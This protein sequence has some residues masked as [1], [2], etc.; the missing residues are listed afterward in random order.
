M[1]NSTHF[2]ITFLHKNIVFLI[3]STFLLCLFS[4]T[5]TAVDSVN[6]ADDVHFSSNIP[7]DVDPALQK[8]LKAEGNIFE[9]NEAFNEYSWQA[10]VAINWP[11]DSEGNAMPNFNDAGIPTWLGWKEAFQVYRKDGGVP[12]DWG[13]P[14]NESGLKLPTDALQN[15]DARMI[16]TSSTP[17]NPSI[18]NIADEVDQAFAGEL[19]DQDGNVVVYEVL[20]NKEEYDYVVDNKLYNINGQIAFS[21]GGKNIANFP[22]G[23]YAGDSLGAI[24]IKFAWKVLQDTDMEERYFTDEGYIISDDTTDPPTLEKVNLGMIGMHISQKTPTGKQWVWST[25]EHIDVLDQNVVEKD[26]K[27][28]VI[29]PSL[30][31]PNCEICPV[32]VDVTAGGTYKYVAG[33]SENHGPYWLVTKKN[34]TTVPGKD[35]EC[36]T[37]KDSLTSSRYYAAY[38]DVMKTQAKRMVDIPIRVQ[39]INQKMQAYFKAN[40][41]V[42][43]YYQLIDTQYPLDQNVPPGP[44]KESDYEIPESVV[45]KPGGNPNVALLTNITMET[46]FQIGNQQASNLIEDNPSTNSLIYGT[47]SCMGCH[48]SAGLYTSYSLCNS[49]DKVV[50]NFQSLGQLSGDFSWLLGKAQWQGAIPSE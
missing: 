2:S 48:S 28:I 20:M 31:D 22:K 23:N 11:T 39:R 37:T 46:Y 47:E 36:S 35:G 13:S 42:W 49:G 6:I 4:C 25:F 3:L 45:N 15:T 18:F 38:G 17:T 16:L 9:L 32:N 30:T 19:F 5:D 40:N 41:S 7:V 33:D 29:P 10:L 27:T 8:R 44:N 12:S 43:Q 34:T 50:Q 21:D 14:R 24:E 1:N 26:G